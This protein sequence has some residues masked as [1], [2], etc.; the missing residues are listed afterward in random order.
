MK[1]SAPLRRS[2]PLK[3]SRIRR[4]P[5]RD[6]GQRDEPY[7]R[8]VR[9]QACAR[10][11]AVHG[12]H[13]HHATA[14]RGYG[15]KAPDYTAV[16]LCALCHRRFHLALA[17]FDVGREGRAQWMAAQAVIHRVRYERWL[18]ADGLL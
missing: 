5:K 11:G 6:D 7:L 1:R 16:P 2:A 18:T 12:I 13:A 8:W 15:Q 9:L 3:R 14:G 17:P 10:C 4:K